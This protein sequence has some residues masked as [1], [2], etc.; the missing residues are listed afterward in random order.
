[1]IFCALAYVFFGVIAWTALQ[2]H[3]KHMSAKTRWFAILAAPIA[4]T[5]LVGLAIPGIVYYRIFNWGAL[6]A[7]ETPQ[8][9]SEGMGELRIVKN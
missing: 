1:M 4:E 9:G 8:N 7:C 5:A 2:P 6:R 3:K